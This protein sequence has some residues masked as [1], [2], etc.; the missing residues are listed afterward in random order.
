MSVFVILE[1]VRA[2]GSWPKEYS[3]KLLSTHPP[4]V[5]Y[6]G[7]RCQ[8]SLVTKMFTVELLITGVKKDEQ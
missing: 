8:V 5:E 7:S 3:W 4:V 2:H 1:I 6:K